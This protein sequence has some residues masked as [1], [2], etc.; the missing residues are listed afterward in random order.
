M[1]IKH[2]NNLNKDLL[3]LSKIDPKLGAVIEQL[4]KVKLR[5]RDDGFSALLRTIVGQQLSVKAAA[6]IWLK[7]ENANLTSE[8]KIEL[9][10]ET[11]LQNCGLSRQ[12]VKYIKALSSEKI[13]YEKLHSLTAEEV[14]EILTAVL[15]IGRWTA[16][17]Y[18]MFSLKNQDIFP[19]GDLAL[20]EATRIIYSLPERPKEKEL[21]EMSL[22]WKPYRSLAALVL[23]E[24]YAKIK[25]REGI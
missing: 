9:A 21:R 1:N 17:I 25:R 7:L 11:D 16:E 10:Q 3:S 14:I 6:A 4:G 15:G 23:W 19:C 12:K 22:D 24:F 8:A 20:Q 5:T 13:D 2:N 18:L